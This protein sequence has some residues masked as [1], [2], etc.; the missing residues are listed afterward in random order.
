M[1]VMSILE[2]HQFL[3]RLASLIRS[4]S[5][6]S[7]GTFDLQPVHLNSLYYLSICNRY[8]DTLLALAE[9]LNQTKGTTSQT[10]KLLEERGLVVKHPDL[11]DGRVGHLKLTASGKKLVRQAWPSPILKEAEEIIPLDQQDALRD[12]LKQLL[13]TCQTTNGQKTF[14]ICHSCRHNEKRAE[15][16]LCRLTQEPLTAEEVTQI[17]REHEFAETA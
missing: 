12:Q 15:G 7:S 2:I 1:K 14:S 16:Y 13:H 3:E 17:C 10:I 6:Q 8:S 11:K 4:Q 9:Y 5:R